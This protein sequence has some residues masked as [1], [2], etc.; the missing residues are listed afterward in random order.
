MGFDGQLALVTGGSSGIGLALA[1]QLAAM[2]SRVWILARDQVRLQAACAEIQQV[3]RGTDRQVDYLS[4]DVVDQKQ[5]EAVLANF[6][7]QA[8]M[9]DLLFNCAGVAHPGRFEELDPQI[10]RWMMDVNYFGTVNV[11]HALVPAMIRR[12]AGHIV[13]ISSIAGFLGLYGYSAYGASKFAVRGLSDVL[14]SELSEFNIAVS[15]VFPPDTQTPQL[16]YEN[17]FKPPLLRKIE[18]SNKVLSAD[19][20]ASLILKGV[21]S[22]RYIITP[23]MDSTLY[24]NLQ[25]LLGNLSYTVMDLVVAQAR[26]SLRNAKNNSRHHDKSNP[27]QV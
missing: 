15:V 4:A 18:E 23:G 13:N 19:T 3:S 11:T 6:V 21:A 22:R 25:N 26:R 17:Q 5:V 9:P 7:N 14:R 8:G 10:F 16:D 27:D 24:Y 1:K 2:G 12:R 20:V